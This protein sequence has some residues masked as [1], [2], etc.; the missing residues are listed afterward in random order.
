MEEILWKNCVQVGSNFICTPL[1]WHQ[2]REGR[3]EKVYASLDV[4]KISH[5]CYVIRGCH[6]WSQISMSSQVEI[7][8][9]WWGNCLLMSIVCLVYQNLNLTI[10]FCLGVN[11]LDLD[12][13]KPGNSFYVKQGHRLK[14]SD[15]KLIRELKMIP[16]ENALLLTGTPLQNNLSE[17]WS[18][19]NFILPEIFTS[20][21][22]FES[23]YVLT[24]MYWIWQ[25]I[26]EQKW[27]H[28]LLSIHMLPWNLPHMHLPQDS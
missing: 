24:R 17:L 12:D 9:S 23:W 19:L 27:M 21:Q 14:N 5:P 4:S 10:I 7:C 26:H 25:M 3:D 1:S 22:Q 8:H 15:C 18:L 2:E 20:L 16:T 6:S 11:F 28:R 13:V